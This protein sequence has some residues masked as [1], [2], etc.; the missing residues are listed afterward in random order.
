[1]SSNELT[2][3]RPFLS[4]RDAVTLLELIHLSLTCRSEADF[5]ALFSKL[6]EL[7]SFDY[8]GT[9]LGRHDEGSGLVIA[10]GINISFPE[11]W[12]TE[13]L[14]NNYFHQDVIT[15]D[16]FRTCKPQHWSYETPRSEDVVAKRIKTFNMDLG[17]KEAYSHGSAPVAR[18]QNGSMFCFASPSMENDVRTAVI[19][20]VVVPH[21][22]LVLNNIFS[23]TQSKSSSL[24]V[25][26]T[27]REKE[28]L[29]WLKQGKS[30]WD[31]S[32][33]LGISERTINYHVYNIMHKLGAI[34]RPQAVANATHLGLIDVG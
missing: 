33:I 3:L 7:F 24:S 6:N 21:L 23:I 10:H 11:E 28:V 22:H 16:T 27:T 12:L 4:G 8:V 14:A 25:V 2:A 9:L 34:N 20:E 29:N 13:Y 26:L 18:G 32:V 5:T 1:M 17:I 31:M 19:L 30:S 15:V